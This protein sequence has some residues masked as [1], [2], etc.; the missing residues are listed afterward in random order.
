MTFPTVHPNGTP[1]ETLCKGYEDVYDALDNA[2]TLMKEAAPNGRDYYPQGDDAFANACNEH[3][4]RAAKIRE[5]MKELESLIGH[6]SK[7]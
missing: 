7:N 4:E 3:R 2:L 5:V 1:K 6:V